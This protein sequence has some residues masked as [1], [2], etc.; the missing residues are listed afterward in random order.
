MLSKNKFGRLAGAILSSSSLFVA[1]SVF[2][3]DLPCVQRAINWN[4][5]GNATTINYVRFS[6]VALHSNGIAAYATGT[7]RNL[8]CSAKPWG[9]GTATCLHSDFTVAARINGSSRARIGMLICAAISMGG[10]NR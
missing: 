2:A 5:G 1:S 6:T 3:A 8:E 7:L 4:N 10:F 9:I